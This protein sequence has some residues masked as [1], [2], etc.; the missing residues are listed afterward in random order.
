VET[1]FEASACTPIWWYEARIS[2]FVCFFLS[3]FVSSLFVY[4][5]I[6]YLCSSDTIVQYQVAGWLVN[7][8]LKRM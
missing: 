2:L 3:F 5:F 6:Y 1:S 8:D 7:S 4:L